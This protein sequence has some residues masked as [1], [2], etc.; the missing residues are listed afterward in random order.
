MGIM[1]SASAAQA[2]LLVYEGFEGYYDK[3]TQNAGD[4]YNGKQSRTVSN[5]LLNG[6][7]GWANTWSGSMTIGHDSLKKTGNPYSS[8]HT[9]NSFQN[10]RFRKM[11]TS[12]NSAVYKAGL[13]ENGHVGKAGK[14]VW[15]SALM[16]LQD[17]N[18]GGLSFYRD[19]QEVMYVGKGDREVSKGKYNRFWKTQLGGIPGVSGDKG[20]HNGGKDGPAYSTDRANPDLVVL[21]MSYAANGVVTVTM[22]VNPNKDA[23]GNPTGKSY[24]VT[25]AGNRRFNR[26]RLAHG[27][28]SKLGFDEFKIGTSYKSV[29]TGAVPEPATMALLAFG[30]VGCL[31]RKR[32]KSAA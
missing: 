11:D 32:K 26:I 7:K 22:W 10:A 24:T 17:H 13:V 18:W 29:T 27:V 1:L 28:N 2:D 5:N 14:T 19:G 21:K 8:G 9:Y 3:S 31:L 25:H 20:T 16:T 4:P 12:A 23:D 15:V 30:G 6:G